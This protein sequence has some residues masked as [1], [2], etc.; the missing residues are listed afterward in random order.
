[1]RQH[2]AG[3]AWEDLMGLF[4]MFR[5]PPADSGSGRACG[6][7][8]RQ[9]RLPDAEGT[10][11]NIR[12][13]APGTTPRCCSANRNF[14]PPSRCRAGAPI[15]WGSRWW[16]RWSKGVL[17]PACRRRSRGAARNAAVRSFS[18]VFD[19]YPVPAALGEHEWRELRAE[20]ARRLQLIGL[21]PPKRAMDIPEQWAQSLFRSDAN[22]REAA[23]PRFSDHPQL[24]AR[25][26]VQHPR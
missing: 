15:R 19:R 12:A 1:M 3:A 11:T 10:S 8:R 26:D 17:R 24:S 22:P 2:G 6:F 25:G 14:R 20:L 21:H 7:H 9:C 5:K 4:D 13:P 18:S 23:R 16:P